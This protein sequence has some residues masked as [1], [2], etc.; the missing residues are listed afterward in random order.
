M[1]RKGRGSG[2]GGEGWGGRGMQLMGK[3]VTLSPPLMSTKFS[4]NYAEYG[5]RSLTYMGPPVALVGA[6]HV[7]HPLHTWDQ[8]GRVAAILLHIPLHT[9]DPRKRGR[10]TKSNFMMQKWLY[11]GISSIIYI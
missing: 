6:I 7:Y 3:H 8:K 9:W 1:E 11:L 4:H 5:H 10:G 2:G